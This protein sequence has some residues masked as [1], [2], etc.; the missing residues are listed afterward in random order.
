MHALSDLNGRELNALVR[1]AWACRAPKPRASASGARALA[2]YDWNTQVSGAFYE[3]LHYL[4]VGLRNAMDA[5][6]TAWARQHGTAGS[7]FD[8][9]VIRLTDTSRRKVR[10][11]SKRVTASGATMNHGKV[12]AELTFGFWW[13]LLADEYNRRLWEPCLKNAFDGSVRCRRLHSELDELRKL[14]NRMAHHE[15]IHVRDLAADFA[16]LLD[17]AGRIASDLKAHIEATS[18]VLDVLATRPGPS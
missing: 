2:L 8:C 16:R 1:A 18:R 12:V 10:E 11:A 15:P 9:P 7:W 5:E 4:E 14:R 17:S 3:S 6:L 13:S